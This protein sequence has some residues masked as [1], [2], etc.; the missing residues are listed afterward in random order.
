MPAQRSY[1]FVSYGKQDLDRIR[2]LLDAVRRELEVRSL[3][4]ELWVDI[5]NLQPGQQ[6]AHVIGEALQLSI[7]ALSFVSHNSLNTPELST[8]TPDELSPKLGLPV[9]VIPVAILVLL[10]QDAKIPRRL[11]SFHVLK[12]FNPLTPEKIKTT[13]AQIAKITES[14][15]KDRPQPKAMVSVEDAPALAAEIAQE[16]RA[17][18]E[19]APDETHPNSVFVVHGHSA[20]PLRQLEDYLASVGVTTIVLSRQDESPQSLFQKFMSIATKARFAI[21]LL[22][23]DDYGASCRQYD[24]AN[25]GDRA[26]QFR[27]RQNVVLEL[28]FFYGRLGWENV[29]VVYQEPNRVFPNFE[30]PS[31]LDG[32]VFDSFS[33]TAWQKKLGAKL[34]AAGFQLAHPV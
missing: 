18:N 31:D 23:A 6:W 10:D 12:F 34:S 19:P 33:D 21:V 5:I 22:C 9:P 11:R 15:L 25:V 29:F 20:E 17:S 32:V 2:P 30:R 26:L 7:G 4:V 3:P 24:T 28:G 27:A 8:N 14:Y 13:A 16:L 1:L